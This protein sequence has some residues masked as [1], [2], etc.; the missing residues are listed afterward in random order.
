MTAQAQVAV[1]GDYT[2]RIGVYNEA[3]EL[4]QT[5][6][7]LQ[8]TQPINDFS[9]GQTILNS[10][11]ARAEVTYEG[12]TI[13]T[14]NGDSQD[15]NPATN[16]TY[17]ISA[18]S[19]DNLGIVNTVT[20]QVTVNRNI[21]KITITVFNEAGEQVR[22]LVNYVDDPGGQPIDGMTLSSS[23]LV[24]GQSSS[25]LPSV[26]SVSTDQG[27]VLGTWDGRSD[28]GTLVSSGQY[29]IEIH[30]ED[31]I[32]GSTTITKRVTVMERG[33]NWEK[34][35]CPGPAQPADF[36]QPAG[37]LLR[38]GLRSPNSASPSVRYGRGKGGGWNA[39]APGDQHSHLGLHQLCVGPLY[40]GGRALRVERTLLGSS[41]YEVVSCPLT[42]FNKL[43]FV[44]PFPPLLQFRNAW[45]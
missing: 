44:S 22:L 20:R 27:T 26:V 29:F 12:V 39:G 32:S 9:L 28:A 11:E 10:L 17:H 3:G 30:S 16:G 6:G 5:L 15:G 43:F 42:A 25:G 41:T 1:I 37:H 33:P 31:G 40:R 4:V 45:K 35:L 13:A 14:W 21:E 2:V 38:R 36:S 19:I 7:V 24:P 18:E 23:V 8:T 34:G